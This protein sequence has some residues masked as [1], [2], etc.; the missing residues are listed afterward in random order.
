VRARFTETESRRPLAREI[1]TV[2]VKKHG[3]PNEIRAALVEQL[4]KPVR[5]VE[6]VRSM[7][8]QG[9]DRIVECGPGRV[10][11]GLNSRIE[12]RQEIHVHAIDD[13]KS[14]DETLVPGRDAAYA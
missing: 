9:V 12:R 10:L 13:P 1:Y 3:D 6:T 4:Y 14:I 2:D 8:A 7:V 11:S 5:W